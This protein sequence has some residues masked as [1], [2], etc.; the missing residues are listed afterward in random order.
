MKAE[1]FSLH[2]EASLMAREGFRSTWE[3]EQSGICATS[4]GQIPERRGAGRL[5][6]EREKQ[7]RNRN[8]EERNGRKSKKRGCRIDLDSFP[9]DCLSLSLRL[10]VAAA[11]EKCELRSCSAV[12]VVSSASSLCIS[13]FSSSL[14]VSFFHFPLLLRPRA[15]GKKKPKNVRQPKKEHQIKNQTNKKNTRPVFAL[16]LYSK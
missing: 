13:R 2:R 3:R 10:C 16:T 1:S 14:F 7:Q 11:A 4:S 8:K 9:S 15:R 6:K 12:C 5:G